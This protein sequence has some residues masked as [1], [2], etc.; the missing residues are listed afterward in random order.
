MLSPRGKAPA[1]RAPLQPP[2]AVIIANQR[3]CLL[4][5]EKHQLDEYHCLHPAAVT[6]ANY[7]R[8][9]RVEA[10]IVERVEPHR[11]ECES[12]SIFRPLARPLLYFCAS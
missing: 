12:L 3:R 1:R 6:I 2:P 11:R 7:R 5:E 8:C 10:T 9:F 4:L